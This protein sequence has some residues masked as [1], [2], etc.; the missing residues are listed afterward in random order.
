MN[1]QRAL[2]T[3]LEVNRSASPVAFDWGLQ[4]RVVFGNDS[5]DRL[6]AI[7][8]SFERKRALVVS[9]PGIVAAGHVERGIQSLREAGIDAILFDGARENP[10]TEHVAAGV[11]L[12]REAQPDL[13]V[14]LGGGSSM[15]CAKGINF[16]HSCGGSMSD[17]WGVDRATGDM[18]PMIG[19]PTTAGTGSELQSFALITDPVTHVKMACG[20]HRASFRV[21]ILDP[22]VTLTQPLAVTA[23]TGIDALSHALETWVTRPRNT[24]SLMVSRQA[25]ELVSQNLQRVLDE[26]GDLDARA[27]ML[28]G[29]AFAGMAIENSMLGAA[30]ALANPLTANYQLPHGHAVGIMLPHVIRFNAREFSEW[31]RELSGNSAD[32]LA[33]FVDGMLRSAGL[34]RKLADCGVER[35][36]I[37]GLAESASKQWTAR[38]NPR[39]V[40]SESLAAL[41]E[42]AF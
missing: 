15:D 20:D 23:L 18:L 5:I 2:E 31:Y 29:A 28:L 21:A 42:Q 41:Y 24:V 12:A 25:W 4:T 13:I 3:V 22:R 26:P 38:F 1:V 27:K 33:A 10:T 8:R 36:A 32:E 35:D 9:D 16:I 14:G 11:E 19:L 30:H 40:T 34:A 17:Y 39:D 7:A 6:G 37:P